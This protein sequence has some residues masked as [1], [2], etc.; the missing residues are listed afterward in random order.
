MK[1][2]GAL[3]NDSA[4]Q[5]RAVALFLALTAAFCLVMDAGTAA[6]A[7]GKKK[8]GSSAKKADKASTA[9]KQTVV[10]LRE[11][12]RSYSAGRYRD[13]LDI[14]T[15]MTPTALTHYYTGLCYHGMNQTRQ[16][17]AEYQWVAS[18]ARDPQL[19]INASKALNSLT[20]YSQ[21]RTYQGQGNVFAR[22]STGY[23]SGPA[24]ASASGAPR[25]S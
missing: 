4:C 8:S 2:P 21:R 18:Y 7:S 14:I 3:P 13:A 22:A 23:T 12:Q 1:E 15:T 25:R 19:R 6:L 10:K 16:A 9:D 24:R 11:V 5:R 17:A 20:A